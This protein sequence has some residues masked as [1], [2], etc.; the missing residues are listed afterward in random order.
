MSTAIDNRPLFQL[1]VSEFKDLLKSALPVSDG[2]EKQSTQTP[3]FK[4][5]GIR[6]LSEF[7]GVSTPTVQK[8]KNKGIIP[9]YNTGGGKVFFFSDEVNASLKVDAKRKGSK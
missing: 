7:L 6:G 8:M 2:V 5:N 4:I 9:F 1:T 3:R